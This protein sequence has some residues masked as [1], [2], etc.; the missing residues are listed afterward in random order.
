MKMKKQYLYKNKDITIRDQVQFKKGT[1][2]KIKARTKV[3]PD[4]NN[5]QLY[6]FIFSAVRSTN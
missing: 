5:V 1:K 6:T 2:V 3:S 4:C